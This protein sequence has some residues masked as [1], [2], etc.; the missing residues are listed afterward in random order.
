[1]AIFSGVYSLSIW[2]MLLFF[3]S[4]LPGVNHRRVCNA[5]WK[6]VSHVWSAQPVTAGQ[7][8]SYRMRDAPLLADHIHLTSG[9]CFLCPFWLICPVYRS[10]ASRDCDRWSRVTSAGTNCSEARC[11]ILKW[12]A[13]M[14]ILSFSACHLLSAVKCFRSL[15]SW[16]IYWWWLLI[17][18][19]ASGEQFKFHRS[20]ETDTW[21]AWTAWYLYTFAR[22]KSSWKCKSTLTHTHTIDRIL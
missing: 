14:Q 1:M 4:L 12:H 5:S 6:I 9:R 7:W 10:L 13:S 20:L 19:W 3:S 17:N 16:L 2:L 8:Q 21:I 22:R 15:D 18:E 11:W